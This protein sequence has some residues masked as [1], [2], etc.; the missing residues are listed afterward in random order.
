MLVCIC[1]GIREKDFR[2]A[3]REGA[4]RPGSAFARCGH[5]VKCGQCLS[6][7]KT[8]LESERVPA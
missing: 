5:R 3:V 7:A 6:F 2:K 1:N 4:S 8:I